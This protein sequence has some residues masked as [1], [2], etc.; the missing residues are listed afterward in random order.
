MRAVVQRVTKASVSVNGEIKGQIGKG[1]VV[2]LGV[3]EGD[4]T[5][6]GDY[7]A[8]K[9]ANLRIFE[10]N[11]GKLNL[12]CLDIKGELLIVSQFTLYGDCRK[13]RRPSFSS[14]AEPGL[15]DRLYRYYVQRISD[16]GLRVATGVF[17]EEMQVEI[18]NQGPVTILLDS[19]K[20]F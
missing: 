11:E 7:L 14:A 10:D 8:D 6:D 9:T 17:R 16:Q 20:D 12:S 3:G 19:R 4:T 1:L 2:L 5:A 15:A 13:G 18:H